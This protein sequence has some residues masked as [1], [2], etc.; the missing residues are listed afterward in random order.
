MIS[1]VREADRFDGFIVAG[2]L[3]DGSK[4]LV[5][6]TGRHGV[7]TEA[8]VEFYY[9]GDGVRSVDFANPKAKVRVDNILV[10]GGDLL[11]LRFTRQNDQPTQSG[12]SAGHHG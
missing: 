7:P 8:T 12:Q 3:D 5:D 11:V 2:S 1:F 6:L 9:A 10:K 4:H